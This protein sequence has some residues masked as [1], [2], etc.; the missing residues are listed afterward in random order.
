MT[1]IEIIQIISCFQKELEKYIV[2]CQNLF[3][4]LLLDKYAI[5]FITKNIY[6][7]KLNLYE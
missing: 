5:Y 1:S 6:Y 2:R 4:N 7:L 3:S